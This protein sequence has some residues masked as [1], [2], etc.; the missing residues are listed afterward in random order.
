MIFEAV[1]STSALSDA[2]HRF[3][4][5]FD[6]DLRLPIWPRDLESAAMIAELRGREDIGRELR[7]ALEGAR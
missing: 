6:M 4:V 2:V 7:L 5:A 1:K 3:N